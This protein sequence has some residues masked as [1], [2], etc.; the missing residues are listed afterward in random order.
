MKRIKITDDMLKQANNWNKFSG[1]RHTIR[2]DGRVSS[3]VGNLGEICFQKMFPQ[4]ER[5][6]DFNFEADFWLKGKHI[7]VKTKDRN[8]YV[9]AHYEASVE[10]RQKDFDCDW[11]AFYSYNKPEQT[12][13]FCGWYPKEQYFEDARRA[14]TG[15]VDFN[16]YWK[17]SVDCYQMQYKELITCRS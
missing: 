7:D 12:M 17:T 4:A 1:N 6:S 9:E 16:N 2:E 3:I 14:S 8:C 10:A 13:E 5:I 11:Y 15:D